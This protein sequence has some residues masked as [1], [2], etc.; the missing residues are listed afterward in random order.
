[1]KLIVIEARSGGGHRAK[2]EHR[3]II[4]CQCLAMQLCASPIA[5]I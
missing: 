4:R 5:A 2:P 3:Q 1:V